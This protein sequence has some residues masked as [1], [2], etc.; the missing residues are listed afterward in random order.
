MAPNVENIVLEQLRLIRS[1]IQTLDEKLNARIDGLEAKVDDLAV[2]AQ[3]TE[4]VLFGLG[5]YVRSIDQRVEHIE[6]KLGID[7]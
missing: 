1:D 3:S 2:R 4:G 5:G 7:Q 6:K